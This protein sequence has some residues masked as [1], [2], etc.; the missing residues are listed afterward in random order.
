MSGSG[1]STCNKYVTLFLTTIFA[2]MH[3]L[4]AAAGTSIRLH[5]VGEVNLEPLTLDLDLE[6]KVAIL[7]GR[8][9]Y[10]I[11]S[12]TDTQVTLFSHYKYA[13]G[14]I[15]VLDLATGDTRGVLIGYWRGSKD[16][17]WKLEAYDKYSIG[18]CR[19][20]IIE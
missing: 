6:G 5:C 1:I 4:P 16:P 9:T 14:E 7:D 11:V 10:A 19:K 13:G 12:Q 18:K 8:K 17:A 15:V 20:S 3:Y 2:M